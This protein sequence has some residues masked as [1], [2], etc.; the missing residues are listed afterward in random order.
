[1]NILMI[2]PAPPRSRY[3]NRVTALRWARILSELGHRVRLDQTYRGESC[4]LMIALHA[5]RSHGAMAEYRGRFP[6]APVVLALTG[7]DIYRD[8]AES[9][10]ARKSL[11]MATRLVTLQS[12]AARELPAAL[13]RKVHLILQSALPLPR[14]AHPAVRRYIVCV[15]G[16]LREVKDP[17]RAALAARGLPQSSRI[18][19]MHAGKAMAPDMARRA[20]EEQKA[21]SRYQWL[22]ELPRWRVRRLLGRSRL[23]VLSSHM[24]GGA[25]V[26]SEAAAAGLP[27]LA[28][29]IP[30]SVGLLGEGYAGFF[31]VGDTDALS[32]LMLRA[33][34]DGDFLAGLRSH[35]RGLAPRF[36][37]ARELAAWKSLL[38]GLNL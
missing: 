23:M 25:N 31:P 30:G 21:N 10:E 37:P 28:S 19:V 20:R 11:H 9:P 36:Q 2:T 38:N 12:M 1:M 24:E 6:D 22:G 27:V 32:E 8:I 3:G 33:E 5:Q 34:C 7:T 26:I 4:D 18:R 14:G 35:M 15:I 17:F 29:R 16:H 13:R